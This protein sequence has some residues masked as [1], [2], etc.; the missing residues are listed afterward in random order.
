MRSISDR[1]LLVILFSFILLYTAVA[2]VT[3][4][5]LVVDLTSNP[6]SHANVLLLRQTDSSLVKGTITNDNGLYTLEKITEGKYLL[7]YSFTG[8]KQVFGRPI[9]ITKASENLAIDKVFLRRDL[10]QLE[11]VTVTIKKQLFEQ[12]IDRMV[13]NVAGS[14]TSAG[15][16]ALDVLERS[17]GVLVD[18]NNN[19]LAI[20]G[21]NGVVVMING[22]VSYMPLNAVVQ[23]LAGMSAGN[24]EKMEIITTPPANL[25]AQGNAGFI[26]IVLKSNPNAGTN[27]SFS[28]SAGYG[29]KENN[30]FDVN[31]NHRKGKFN[32]YGT[33][34]LSRTHQLQSMYFYRKVVIESQVV[35]TSTNSDRDPLR[36]LHNARAG[37]DYQLTKK[38]VIGGIA[39]VS[40]NKWTMNAVNNMSITVDSQIDSLIKINNKELNRWKNYFGNINVQHTLKGDSKISADVDYVYYNDNNPNDYLNNYYK[41]T[42]TFLFDENTKSTKKTPIN[43]FAA[44]IDYTGKIG[45]KVEIEAGGKIAN[46][47]FT[48]D[49]AVAKF[50]QNTW[51]N[52]DTL[53]ASY[54]LKERILAAY[55]S[56]NIMVNDKTTIK[57][58]LR[59]EYTTSNL[60]TAT[61]K[62]IVDRK[63]GLLFPT[64]YVSRKINDNILLILLIAVE[65]QGQLLMI[66]LP[67]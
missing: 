51:K 32:L 24:I 5:G 53:T 1:F 17:P 36:A 34:S 9:T 23:M 27:G 41:G 40:D 49:V 14:I 57:A 37:I 26:N 13:I 58:G 63:Y 18:R 30:S 35:E 28:L 43:I 65:L 52:D 56:V 46:S 8:Y 10:Q 2:Q 38:T 50:K 12:K 55:T 21:K 16:T 42:G 54:K 44:K 67:L 39:G 6:V 45:K 3:I 61:K 59:Y 20:N 62:N 25:D 7:S 60:G 33:Y 4:T 48:N 22:K 19:S 15:S 29:N 31:I 66:L 47:A 11:D 64:L